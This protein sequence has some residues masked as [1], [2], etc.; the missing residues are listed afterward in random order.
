[1][2]GE[3]RGV[4]PAQEF[5]MGCLRLRGTARA[6]DIGKIIHVL[7]LQ[8]LSMSIV[9]MSPVPILQTDEMFVGDRGQVQIACN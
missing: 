5:L 6:I 7:Q 2:I 8:R 1:M 9:Q 4:L 3:I